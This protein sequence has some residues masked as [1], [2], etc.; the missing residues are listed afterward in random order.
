M[1][2][3]I[4]FDLDDTLYDYQALHNKAMNVLSKYVGEHFGVDA[5]QF[6]SAWADAR[7]ETKQAQGNTAASHNRMLY[8]QKTLEKLELPP[9]YGALEMYEAYWGYILAQMSLREGVAELLT[10]C[11]ERGIKIGI[12]SD[13]TAHIQHCKLQALGIAAQIDCLVTSEE[14]GVEKPDPQ[15]FQMILKKLKCAPSEVLYIGDNLERDIYGAA[16]CGI[17]ALWLTRNKGDNAVK[18]F[19]EVRKWLKWA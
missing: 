1:L 11:K 7:E 19:W 3:A 5:E 10:D 2:K 14:A 13:L 8:C 12:C 18:N 9:A 4:V 15:I 6:R 16:A 17:S